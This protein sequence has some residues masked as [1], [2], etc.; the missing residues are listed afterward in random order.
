MRA[1]YRKTAFYVNLSA[2]ENRKFAEATKQN[3]NDHLTFYE[4]NQVNIAFC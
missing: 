1:L 2:N 3:I 4:L